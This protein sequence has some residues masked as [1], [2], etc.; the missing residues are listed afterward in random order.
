M[1]SEQYQVALVDCLSKVESMLGTIHG[2]DDALSEAKSRRQIIEAKVIEMRQQLFKINEASIKSIGFLDSI[3]EIFVE[4][5]HL[6]SEIQLISMSS[7]K[8]MDNDDTFTW[9]VNTLVLLNNE[10]GMMHS[11]AF[12]SSQWGYKM[13]ISICLEA[14][15]QSLKRFLLIY[16]FIMRGAY[17]SILHWP[18]S[19]P[20]TVCLVDLVRG[21]N[22]MVHSIRPDSQA[23]MFGKPLNEA[24]TPYPI[25]QFCSLEKLSEDGS[26]YIQDG[27]MFLKLHICFTGEDVN[28]FESIDSIKLSKS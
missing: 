1:A 13:R 6:L 28:P 5:H 8:I 7:P 22:H 16:F 14:D 23:A 17:D 19:Y 11:D 9:K 10:T 24:N 15:S 27:Y 20:I 26:S 21:Q 18:F 2:T 3:Q 12:Q 25:A 4:T